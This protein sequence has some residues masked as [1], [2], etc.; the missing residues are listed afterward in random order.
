[1]RAVERIDLHE[2]PD[3]TSALAREAELLRRLRPRFNRAGTWP[4]RPRFLGWRVTEEGLALA[5]NGETKSEWHSQG[6]VWE[7]GQCRS[8]LRSSGYC[9]V[10]WSPSA[11]SGGCPLAG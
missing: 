1:M 5:V 9:G 8:E 2:C 6:P 3:E 4:G 11:G 10:R 7:L